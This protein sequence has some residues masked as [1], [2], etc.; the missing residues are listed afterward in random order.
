MQCKELERE[1]I[2][3]STAVTSARVLQ[4]LRVLATDAAHSAPP[5]EG[6]NLNSLT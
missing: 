4:K 2:E 1:R 6:E 5:Y 3:G